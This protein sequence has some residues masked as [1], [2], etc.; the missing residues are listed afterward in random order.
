[1]HFHEIA[2]PSMHFHGIGRKFDALPWS[3]AAIPWT[4][5][6]LSFDA[7]ALI[8]YKQFYVILGGGGAW[9]RIELEKLFS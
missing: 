1:M 7:C 2:S 3:H 5:I 8:I 6:Q 9:K 4:S